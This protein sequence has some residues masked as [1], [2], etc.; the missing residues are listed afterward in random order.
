MAFNTNKKLKYY[1]WICE[2]IRPTYLDGSSSAFIPDTEEAWGA[3]IHL[4]SIHGVLPTLHLKL[5]KIEGQQSAPEEFLEALEGFYELNCLFNS[6]LREQIL[7]TTRTLNEHKISPVWL[8]G[9][10]ALLSSNWERMPRSMLDL[11]LWIPEIDEQTKTLNILSNEGYSIQPESIGLDY[12]LHQHYAPI[13]KSGQPARLE[14]HRS[15]TPLRCS[16][17]LS[18]QEAASQIQW[19]NNQDSK[20]GIPSEEVQIIQSYLQCTEQASDSNYP[21]TTPRLMKI[22]DFLERF[23]SKEQLNG[24]FASNQGLHQSPWKHKASEF[25]SHLNY[26]FGCNIDLPKNTRYLRRITFAINL[27]R[28]ECIFFIISHGFKLLISGKLGGLY[29]W[30]QKLQRKITIFKSHRY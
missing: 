29:Q 8:K 23:S 25:A 16:S 10:I 15:I 24:W 6:S 22:L 21:R 4:G 13:I 19:I 9:S 30:P 2:A 3:I 14:I 26:F 17:L 18:S 20:Y 27:P 5:N 1:Q 7:N 28:L 11:D 12:S